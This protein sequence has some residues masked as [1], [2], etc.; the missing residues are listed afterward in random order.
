MLFF[1]YFTSAFQQDAE[2]HFLP[3]RDPFQEERMGLIVNTNM[4]SLRAQRVLTRNS[5]SLQVSFERLSSGLRVNSAKDDAAGLAIGE[6]M[7]SQIRGLNQAVRNAN[8]AASLTKVA[9]GALVEVTSILQRMREL[10]VQ[11]ANDT[12]TPTDRQ[13]LQLEVDALTDELDRIATQTQY[14]GGNLLDG[15]FTNRVFQIGANTGQTISFSI[16]GLS[17]NTIGAIATVSTGA[18]ATTNSAAAGDLIVNGQSIGAPQA[19][20][21]TLSFSGNADSAIAKAAAINQVSAQTGVTATVDAAVLTDAGAVGA[22]TAG[23]GELLING[24]DIGAVTIVGNDSDSALRNA[25]NAVSGQTGVAA[26]LS[27]TQQ[28]VL[29]AVDGRNITL[30]GT[31]ASLSGAIG[32]TAGTNAGGITLQSDNQINLTG[33]TPAN[34]GL[35]AGITAVNSAVNVASQALTNQADATNAIKVYDDAVRQVSSLRA[36]LGAIMNRLDMAVNNLSTT[37]ENVSAARSRVMDADFA[38][39][40]A[41]FARNQILQQASAAMLAQANTSGQIALQLL[42]GG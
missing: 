29:T 18:L 25:I 40:T 8:D 9:E 6:R 12:N 2:K 28:L 30:A 14:N 21:D 39:E 38:A 15:S 13:A 32:F 22:A 5:E 4:G 36:S 1:V 42:G 16:G 41:I 33:T 37:S 11:A 10:S 27:T 24:V 35:G 20:S 26:T 7:S 31:D 34:Y 3:Y 17:S 23:A 19:A